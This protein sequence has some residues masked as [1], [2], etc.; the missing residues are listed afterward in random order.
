[1]G[2][3]A[4]A[5]GSVDPQAGQAVLSVRI[6]KGQ[7]SSLLP[8]RVP[9]RQL[10]VPSCPPRRRCSTAGTA[11]GE[12]DHRYSRTAVV[13]LLCVGSTD[14][15][16]TSEPHHY[17]IMATAA[18]RIATALNG[19]GAQRESAYTT[20]SALANGDSADVGTV[21]STGTVRVSAIEEAR[22][23]EGTLA[24]L[25]GQFGSVLAVTLRCDGTSPWALLTFG[26]AKEA[27]A[28]VAAADGLGVAVRTVD[29]HEEH[30]EQ[31]LGEAMIAIQEH[32]KR[33]TV[34]V[35]VS[36]VGPLV[37][38]VLCADVSVVGPVE[39]RRAAS[40]L[41]ELVMLDPLKVLAEYH[42]GER[43]FSTWKTMGNAL[44][45]V[46]LKQPAELTHDD[47]LTVAS[48]TTLTVEWWARGPDALL[49]EMG[50]GTF[51]LMGVWLA[52][53]KLQ[54]GNASEAVIDRLLQLALEIVRDPQGLSK[55]TQAGVWQIF[56]WSLSG[57]AAQAMPVIEAGLLKEMV[58][59]MKQSSPVEWMTWKTSS[60]MLAGGIFLLGWTLSTLQLPVN[61][62]QLLLD[63]GFIDMCM[64]AL[65]AFE[66]Q[67]AR[68]V[69]ETNI[70]AVEEPLNLLALLDLTAPEAAPIVRSLEGMP[71]TLRFILD[72]DLSFLKDMGY[73]T[74]S[75]CAL[76]CAMAMGKQEGGEFEFTQNVIDNILTVTLEVFSGIPCAPL[77]PVLA[78]FFMKSISNLCISGKA[79]PPRAA[80]PFPYGVTIR[81]SG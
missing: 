46:F 74:A 3:P 55:L 1:M 76:T 39:Y 36:C 18:E 62:T 16:S 69:P 11:S 77:N 26:E 40:V 48:E 14:G 72:N 43:F 17:R 65:K 9:R 41:A 64:T 58:A 28:S 35:A 20:L 47:V 5:G 44:N 29:T 68:N 73:T 6:L 71:S 15:N 32:R 52:N 54:P 45:A 34:G 37:D 25:F 67:G 53:D 7:T 30:E 12:Y 56:G 80:C 21:L 63:S 59:T 60:G 33:V 50:V 75:M 49:E 57:R 61:K 2:P 8:R 79:P 10:Y 4:A 19:D 24:E 31:P 70:L 66:L 42:R 27:Q 78:P 22:L 51:D 23:D 13:V 81:A 38:T